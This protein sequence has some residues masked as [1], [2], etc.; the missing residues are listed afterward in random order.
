V[1][2]NIVLKNRSGQLVNCT[3]SYTLGLEMPASIEGRVA[4]FG[5]EMEMHLEP[6]QYSLQISLAL[7]LPQKNNGHV[8]DQTPSLG[9]LTISW[10]YHESPPPFYGIVGLP[11]SGKALVLHE[12][13][14]R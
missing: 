3:S 13:N 5:L 8:L 12:H 14:S 10:D 6:G 11:V 9:P 1:H 4:S 2:V 7:A